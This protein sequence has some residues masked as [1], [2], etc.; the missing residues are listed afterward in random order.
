MDGTKQCSRCKTVKTLDAF[1][2][3][4]NTPTGKAYGCKA[5]V[6]VWASRSIARNKAKHQNQP[7][8][9][10]WIKLC[11]KCNESKN[12]DLFYRDSS[13]KDGKQGVC[14]I[15]NNK[16][17]QNWRNRNMDQVLQHRKIYR[18]KPEVIEK[19]IDYHKKRKA[20]DPSFKIASS[21]RIRLNGVLNGKYKVGSAVKDLGC[22][23]IEL[24]LYLESKFS[25]G[26]NWVNYG[27][28]WHI[29]HIQPLSSFDLTKREDFLKACHYNNLQPLWAK[30][31]LLKGSKKAQ[32]MR[33][34]IN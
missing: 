33:L 14:K 16:G 19:N 13:T 3:D 15:C 2:N 10:K 8:I 25:E 20:E 24:K 30:D 7:H 27:R 34:N 31:N 9:E 1:H 26:M 28:G 23:P 17:S 18:K 29:D 22:S 5:C 6:K 12:S 4:K 21:L 32:P 11:P